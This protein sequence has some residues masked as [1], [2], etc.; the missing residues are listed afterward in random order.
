MRIFGLD[1][2]ST[3]SRRKPITCVA[4]TLKGTV[5]Q[6]Q[7]YLA[8]PTFAA[9]EA[10][11]QTPGPWLAA[12]DFPFGQPRKLITNLH[13]PETWADYI[14]LVAAMDKTTFEATLT[15]YRQSR[16][17]GDKQHLRATDKL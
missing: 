12:C 7:D 14:Q 6:V 2:T 9:F 10:F 15:S 5:L 8:I 11:L 17:M 1:F 3:P 16:P 13:W 4:C